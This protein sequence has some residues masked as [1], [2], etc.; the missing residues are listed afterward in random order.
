MLS[1]M[2]A[3]ARLLPAPFSSQAVHFLRLAS[4]ARFSPAVNPAS[5]PQQTRLLPPFGPASLTRHQITLHASPS[6]S[7]LIKQWTAM[8]SPKL[9]ICRTF[10]PF[11]CFVDVRFF[12]LADPLFL[13]VFFGAR[14]GLYA[15]RRFSVPTRAKIALDIPFPIARHSFLLGQEWPGNSPTAPTPVSPKLSAGFSG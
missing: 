8:R 14:R 7:S 11:S 3:A 1:T 2:P 9:F 12:F 13:E 15:L 4:D 5:R 10:R 6:L